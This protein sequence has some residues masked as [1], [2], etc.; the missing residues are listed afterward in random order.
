MTGRI[1][2]MLK[3][4]ADELHLS[5][6]ELLKQSLRVFPERQLQKVEAEILQITGRHGVL[7]VE[8]EAL[9]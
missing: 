5:E 6:E 7:G 1:E 8:E 2:T 9:S 4:V 3:A